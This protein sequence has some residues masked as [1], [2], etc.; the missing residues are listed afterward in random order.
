MI[1]YDAVLIVDGPISSNSVLTGS[2]AVGIIL[3]DRKCR[4]LDGT[5]IHTSSIETIINNS[6]GLYILTRNSTYKVV[7]I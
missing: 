7:V 6:T 3:H 1:D 5:L 4:F 2:S